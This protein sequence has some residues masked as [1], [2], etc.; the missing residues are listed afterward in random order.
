MVGAQTDTI[1]ITNWTPVDENGDPTGALGSLLLLEG[2][3]LPI[4]NNPLVSSNFVIDLTGSMMMQEFH[5]LESAIVNGELIL[6]DA[7][8]LACGTN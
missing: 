2:A 8:D 3:I 4:P 1:H 7:V 5:V 6:D